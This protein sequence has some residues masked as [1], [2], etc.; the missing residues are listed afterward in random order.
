MPRV[1]LLC[2]Y[3]LLIIVATKRSTIANILCTLMHADCMH[4]DTCN[5]LRSLVQSVC[6]YI[7]CTY[8][9]IKI[10][11]VACAYIAISSKNTFG[12]KKVRPSKVES[13]MKVNT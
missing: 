1:Y 4:I 2:S 8:I 7:Q 3:K 11:M 12:V 13:Y 6:S 5:Q 10:L 9:H